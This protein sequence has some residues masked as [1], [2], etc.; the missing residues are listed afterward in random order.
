MISWGP[1]CKT[2]G[3]RTVL[4]SDIGGTRWGT[5]GVEGQQLRA[6]S[7]G[8]RPQHAKRAVSWAGQACEAPDLRPRSSCAICEGGL[9]AGLEREQRPVDLANS[10]AAEREIRQIPAIRARGNF[11]NFLRPSLSVYK[12]CVHADSNQ[13]HFRHQCSHDQ[14]LCSGPQSEPSLRL[15]INSHK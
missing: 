3:L 11:V 8:H 12:V 2:A 10:G 14:D 15:L 5:A 4:G 1:Y 7:G 9:A 6:I 13:T